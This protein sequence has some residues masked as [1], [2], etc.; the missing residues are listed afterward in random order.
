M[1]FDPAGSTLW[2]VDLTPFG[3]ASNPPGGT[4]TDVDVDSE[5]NIYAK[6]AATQAWTGGRIVKFAP[7]GTPLWDVQAGGNAL[8]VTPDGEVW[9]VDGSFGPY[10]GA[11][12]FVVYDS[13][14]TL[15]G[16]NYNFGGFPY[17]IFALADG[18]IVHHA[19]NSASL[20]IIDLDASSGWNQFGMNIG[21]YFGLSFP[22]PWNANTY[23]LAPD[24][25]SNIWGYLVGGIGLPVPTMGISLSRLAGPNYASTLMTYYPAAGPTNAMPS[26]NQGGKWT[27]YDYAANVDPWGDLD[28][29]GQMNRNELLS[30]TNP[31]D[32]ASNSAQLAVVNAIAGQTATIGLSAGSDGG[33]PYFAIL[34]LSNTVFDIYDGRA[35]A[36]SPV[37]PLTAWTLTPGNAGVTGIIGSLDSLGAGAATV[38]VPGNAA[39]IGLPVHLG[40]VTFSPLASQGVKTIFG[41]TTIQI[42]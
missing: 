1:K 40:F 29:D 21:P 3:Q 28:G 24:C 19:I 32:A 6:L 11:Y 9:T 13:T 36:P 4:I 37:D 25:S 5:G 22:N 39:L 33:L 16:W 15:I 14:G 2:D 30:G 18:R 7:D 42:Q 17:D 12:R 35:V 8:A 34:S 26:P 20:S 23:A 38:A 31:C 10:Q 41:P 27:A